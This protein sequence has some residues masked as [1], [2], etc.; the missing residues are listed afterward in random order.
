MYTRKY[1]RVKKDIAI[2]EGTNVDYE[3]SPVTKLIP[4][5]DEC[6]CAAILIHIWNVSHPQLMPSS[7]A[8][9]KEVRT[10]NACFEHKMRHQ[11]CPADCRN[12]GTA[13]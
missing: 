5:D 8:S 7:T 9:N 3:V 10:A 1:R 11:K 4:V 6:E 2:T 13:L 12:R